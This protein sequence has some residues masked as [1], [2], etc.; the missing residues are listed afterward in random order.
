MTVSEISLQDGEI[1]ARV[2]FRYPSEARK[3]S[4]LRPKDFARQMRNH[5]GISLLRLKYL[6]K[7]QALDWVPTNKLKGLATCESNR[8]A[9]LGLVFLGTSA[10]DPHVSARC[11]P[12]DLCANYPVLC[13]PME[14]SCSLDIETTPN[15]SEILSKMFLVDIPSC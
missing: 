12:C 5:S 14:A 1:I 10:E 13:R 4:E 11:S 3:F 2:F 7:R 15:L 6:S 9:Q 8:L